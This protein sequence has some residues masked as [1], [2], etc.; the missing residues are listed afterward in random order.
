MDA[1]ACGRRL[2]TL[3]I[4]DDFNREALHIEVDTSITSFQLVRLFEQLKRDHG[5]PQILRT[6]NGPEFRGEAFV[7]WAKDNGMAIQYIQPGKPNQNAYIERFNR[8]FREEILDPYLFLKIDD[9]RQAA[10]WWMIEYN[11]RRPHDSLGGKTP[12]EFVNSTPAALLYDCLLDGGAYDPTAL[13]RPLIGRRHA[14]AVLARD[15]CIDLR[16]DLGAPALTE[17]RRA[18]APFWRKFPEI[19]KPPPYR[20]SPL[21]KRPKE[22]PKRQPKY[23]AKK[24]MIAPYI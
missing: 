4:V 17:S 2:R 15:I 10:Y 20:R 6:D 9:L 12:S 18:Y 11:E 24:T 1:L 16:H 19:R 21:F 3:N 22:K 14:D 5:L 7:Q 13:G 8:T 23:T